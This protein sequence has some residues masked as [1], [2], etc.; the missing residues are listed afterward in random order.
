MFS[1]LACGSTSTPPPPVQKPAA[2]ILAV[3]LA[4]MVAEDGE[5]NWLEGV[6]LLM[7]YAILGVAFFF[8]P[9]GAAKVKEV[10]PVRAGQRG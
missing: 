6:M 3:V 1:E 2:V 7:I 4:W 5:S 10:E 9:D 8:L